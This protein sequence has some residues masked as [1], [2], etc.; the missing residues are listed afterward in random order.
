MPRLLKIG[1]ATRSV[2]DGVAELNSASGVPA[3]FAVEAWFESADPQ[4][5]G[6]ESHKLL[7]HCRLPNRFGISGVKRPQSSRGGPYHSVAECG[8]RSLAPADLQLALRIASSTASGCR[9]ITA[10]STRA[11]PSGRVRPCSQFFSVAGWN[12]NLAANAAWLS[13]SR[14]R[15]ARTSTVGTSTVVTRTATSLPSAHA[16]ASFRLAMIRLPALGDRC[17]VPR[18]FFNA[19]SFSGTPQRGGATGSSF[20]SVRPLSDW[21][22]VLLEY[23]VQKQRQRLVVVVI[24]HSHATALASSMRPPAQLSAPASLRH[25][26]ACLRVRRQEPDHFAQFLIGKRCGGIP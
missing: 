23:A 26:V 2:G 4:S 16:T 13:P 19:P 18:F 5:H 6:A 20:R 9:A 7:A 1:H 10:S 17:L 25:Y 12:P 15:V 14:L 3:P 8:R 21:P 24:N 22:F 11:G